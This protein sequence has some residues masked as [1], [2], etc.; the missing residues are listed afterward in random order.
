[1]AHAP[2]HYYSTIPSAD[3]VAA[4]TP[5]P[6]A[7]IDLRPDAQVALLRRLAPSPPR[8]P[9]FADNGYYDNGDA[10]IYQ[11]IVRDRRPQRVVEVGGGWSTAALF[12]AGGA[13]EVTV[14]DPDPERVH[15]LLLPEDRT[16]CTIHAMRLQDLAL[17]PF[18]ALDAG[19][20]LFVDSTHVVKAGSDVRRLV[21]EIFPLLRPGVAVH[22]HDVQHGF[23]YRRD[24]LDRGLAW[25]EAYVLRAFLQYN[26]AFTIMLWA[27]WLHREG[28]VEDPVVDAALARQTSA[29]IWIERR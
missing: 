1:M 18:R 26:D 28:L 6:L 10:A 12:D 23:E 15:R 25:N 13:P 8:G 3:D 16:R 9:R 2:G 24:W 4:T 19:D 5:L 14:V 20:I 17:D 11:A 21:F 29:A 22:V 7:G 27:D